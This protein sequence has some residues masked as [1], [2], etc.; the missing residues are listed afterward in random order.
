M[1]ETADTIRPVWRTRLAA[2]L[3]AWM[4]LILGTTLASSRLLEVVSG[5]VLPYLAA[6]LYIAPIPVFLAWGFWAMLREPMT[7]WL[8]P[9]IM[10]TFCGAF[11]AG[12]PQLFG[13]GVMLN[14]LAHRPTY[15]A[16]VADVATGA[17]GGDRAQRGWIQARQGRVRYAFQA[18]HRGLVQFVW[19]EQDYLPAAVVY[20]AKACGV[21]PRPGARRRVITTYDRHLGGHYC[22]VSEF[23]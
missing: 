2:A 1:G 12:F 21:A 15:D 10:L 19:S 23:P 13:A 14:F 3:V 9:T 16:I 20:D 5:H 7:G 8:A 17:I 6:A 22:Y 11:I 4:G 18:G